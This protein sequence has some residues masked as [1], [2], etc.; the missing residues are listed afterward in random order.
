MNAKFFD[1]KQDK[2]DR[3][4]NAALKVFAL[5]GYTHASTD[6]I[7]KEAHISKGL[8]FHYFESKIGAYAFVYDY[9]ARYMALEFSTAVDP[10]E[11]SYMTIRKQMEAAKL[12]TLKNYPYM[13]LFLS[14]CEKETCPEALLSIESNRRAYDNSVGTFLA[15]ADMNALKTNDKS[16]RY[17]KMLD[18]TLDA[19][20][21]EK[22]REDS[23]SADEYYS[24]AIE[25]MNIVEGLMK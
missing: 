5:N 11:T 18:C 12:Q 13:Q 14:R 23:F 24:E 21:E 9:A 20:M 10:S 15:R 17:L 19:I 6:E 8:L 4:I 1:L 22:F 25:Y 16:Y 2:Q 7:V 3:M